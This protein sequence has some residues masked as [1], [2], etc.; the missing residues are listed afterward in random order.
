MTATTIHR[1][2]VSLLAILRGLRRPQV[3]ITLVVLSVGV[4]YLLPRTGLGQ[5]VANDTIHFP[6]SAGS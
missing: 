4:W 1:V 2:K 6:Q 5:R 3:W